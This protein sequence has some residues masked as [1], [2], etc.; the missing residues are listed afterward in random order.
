MKRNRVNI[1]LLLAM[2]GFA[3]ANCQPAREPASLQISAEHSTLKAGSRVFI[4]V[5]MTNKSMHP[6]DCSVA[7]SSGVDLRYRFQV[8]GPT[9]NVLPK[10]PRR[11]P[12]LEGAGSFSLCTLNPGESTTAE[13]NLLN[14]LFDMSQP[15][16]YTIQL[17]RVIDTPSGRVQIQSNKLEI[18]ITP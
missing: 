7:Y 11:H 17:S 1:L 2:T 18:N 14:S 10:K 8:W 16:T 3:V 4:E 6:I 12:E 9:G 13:G 15:G 5:S